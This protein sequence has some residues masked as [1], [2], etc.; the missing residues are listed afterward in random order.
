MAAKAGANAIVLR[1]EV[2]DLGKV[3]TDL[4]MEV[5]WDVRSPEEI[6]SLSDAAQANVFLLPGCL[7]MYKLQAFHSM[8]A[9]TCAN[10]LATPSI[11]LSTGSISQPSSS[12]AASDPTEAAQFLA[13]LPQGAVGVAALDRQNN[14]IVAGRDLAKAGVKSLILRQV[15][16]SLRVLSVSLCVRARA[17][18]RGQ[19][20]SVAVQEGMHAL[21]CTRS[22]VRTLSHGMDT[23][24][25]CWRHQL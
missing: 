11:N 5:I 4:K 2:A 16:V 6:S 10:L 3:A 14:E 20:V 19:H 1:S 24:G 7:R 23:P 17:R 9:T 15:S 21:A 18:A 25:V 13:A 22:L 12:L 8:H